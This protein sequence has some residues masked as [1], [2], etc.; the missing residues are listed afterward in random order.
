[1]SNSDRSVDNPSHF[2]DESLQYVLKK[3]DGLPGWTRGMAY[4]YCDGTLVLVVHVSFRGL[5]GEERKFCAT[6]YRGSEMV[7]RWDAAHQWSLECKLPM[8][9][10]LESYIER[11]VLV[12]VVEFIE[13]PEKGRFFLV[14]SIVRLRPLDP[15]LSF[16]AESGDSSLPLRLKFH[17]GVGNRELESV[18][19]RRRLN[20]ALSNGNGIERGIER[21][22]EIMDAITCDQGPSVQRGLIRDFDDKAIVGTLSVILSGDGIRATPAPLGEF[23]IESIE[24]FFG[25]SEFQQATG[26]LRSDHAIRS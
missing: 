9:N 23:G 22:P 19:L 14:R 13:N 25:A 5:Q 8:G 1:M 11:P 20:A 12:R 24:V 2:G 15:C 16:T 26:E 4:G 18:G 17:R 3:G 21:G 7:D 6:F 10:V